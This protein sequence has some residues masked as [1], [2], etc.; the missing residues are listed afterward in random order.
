MVEKKTKNGDWEPVFMTPVKD[1]HCTVPHLKEGEEYQFRVSAVN[2][3]GPG[4]LSPPTLPVVA[5]KPKGALDDLLCW[6]EI[7]V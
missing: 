3:A 4:T 2:E 5:E 7:C 1:P 6:F